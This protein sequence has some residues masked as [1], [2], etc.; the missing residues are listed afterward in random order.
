MLIIYEY[1]V[2]ALLLVCNVQVRIKL[3]KGT[4]PTGLVQQR[5]MVEKYFH[6]FIL[7]FSRRK[8]VFSPYILFLGLTFRHDGKWKGTNEA[9]D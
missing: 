3:I 5:F 8:V 7:L 6:V 1:H 4:N 9:D 2:N